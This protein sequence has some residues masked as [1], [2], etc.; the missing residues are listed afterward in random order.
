VLNAL[1]IAQHAQK[2]QEKLLLDCVFPS[3][4]C[5]PINYK[6]HLWSKG[7]ASCPQRAA[8]EARDAKNTENQSNA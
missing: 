5:P 7:R 4:A 8:N 2:A 3:N 1:N 6:P